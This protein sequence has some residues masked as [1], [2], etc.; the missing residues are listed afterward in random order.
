M[1]SGTPVK[2]FPPG[3]VSPTTRLPGGPRDEAVAAGAVLHHDLLAERLREL[4][5]HKARRDVGDAARRIGHDQV[6]RLV[7]VGFGLKRRRPE[8]GPRHHNHYEPKT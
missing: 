4:R 1:T 5:P 7:W 6:D 8:R 3:R 2:P